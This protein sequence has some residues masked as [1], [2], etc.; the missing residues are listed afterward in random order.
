VSKAKVLI[1]EEDLREAVEEVRSEF[2][3]LE[4]SSAF[5][6][7]SYSGTRAFAGAGRVRRAACV[8]LCSAP[9]MPFVFCRMYALVMR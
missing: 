8:P 4:L 7:A 9:L 2:A 5:V 6:T 3:G 1:F